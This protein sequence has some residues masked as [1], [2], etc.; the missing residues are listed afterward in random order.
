VQA[1]Q[2]Q[3]QWGRWIIRLDPLDHIQVPSASCQVVPPLRCPTPIESACPPGGT[4]PFGKSTSDWSWTPG[5]TSRRVS[6]G[7]DLFLP[8]D[9]GGEL[10]VR[11]V[12]LVPLFRSERFLF[13]PRNGRT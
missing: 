1:L 9:Y 11:L 5:Q 3:L 10:L 6:R 4:L 12:V 2:L 8:Y 7:S 13:V